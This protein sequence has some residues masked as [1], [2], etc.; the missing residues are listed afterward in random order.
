MNHE[1]DCKPFY[2]LCIPTAST[3]KSWLNPSFQYMDEFSSM[4]CFWKSYHL[5]RTIFFFFSKESIEFN[6]GRRFE[7]LH[8]SIIKI[9]MDHFQLSCLPSAHFLFSFNFV[10]PSFWDCVLYTQNVHRYNGSSHGQWLPAR[11][12]L[13]PNK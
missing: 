12:H 11:Q 8:V 2:I 3:L 13:W 1:P 4:F 10:L 9:Y 5:F 6:I 7:Y